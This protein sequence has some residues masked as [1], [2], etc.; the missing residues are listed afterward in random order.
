[1]K[2]LNF[3]SNKTIETNIKR[4]KANKPIKTKLD[5]TTLS[6]KLNILSLKE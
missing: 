4:I 5:N 2:I 1:M 6:K 3:S